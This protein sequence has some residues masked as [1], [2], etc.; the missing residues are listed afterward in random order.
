M[1]Y[2]ILESSDPRILE[3]NV[4][5]MIQIGWKPLGGVSISKIRLENSKIF[6]HY[7]QTLINDNQISE[8]KDG[9]S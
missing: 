7:I 3:D 8:S 4:N 6:T 9:I 2:K 5:E 1:K